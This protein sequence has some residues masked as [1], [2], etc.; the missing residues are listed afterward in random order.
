[1]EGQSREAAN[2]D[3]GEMSESKREAE[4]KDKGIREL[5]RDERRVRAEK[6]REVRRGGEGEADSKNV[7]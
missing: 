1:M 5:E 4:G 7:Q 6:K 2:G 3:A